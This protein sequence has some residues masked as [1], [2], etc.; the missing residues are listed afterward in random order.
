M[1]DPKTVQDQDA[2]RREQAFLSGFCQDMESPLNV[3]LTGAEFL[4]EAARRSPG[5]Y[6]P[7]LEHALS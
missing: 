5:C 2:Q 1:D 6:T 3:I 4:A 7:Q